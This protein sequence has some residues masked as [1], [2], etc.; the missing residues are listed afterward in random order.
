[1]QEK[2]T[3]EKADLEAAHR[4]AFEELSA[5]LTKEKDDMAQ[6]L[7]EQ[8]KQ[9]EKVCL[10]RCSHSRLYVSLLTH[11]NVCNGTGAHGAWCL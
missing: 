8:H 5:H 6:L 11:A 10:L 7:T 1:M 4:Q 9:R 2:F 3:Q